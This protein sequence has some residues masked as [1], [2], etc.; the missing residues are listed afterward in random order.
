M[1][2][3]AVIP[4]KSSSSRIKNK[5]IK[6]LGDK[7]LFIHTLEKLLLIEELD[8]VWIDTDSHDIIKLIDDYNYTDYK[9][10]I[11]DKKY[12]NNTCDG[13]LLLEN[14]INNIN[15]D[16]YIQVLCTS[17]FTTNK[18]IKKCID[19]LKSKK[20]KSVIGCYKD[21]LYLWNNNKPIYDI[22]NIPNSNTLN[23][24]IIESM[25]IYGIT[26]E[27]FLK[28]KIRIGSNPYLLSLDNEEKIDINY[29][30]DFIFAN[31]R[32]ELI[33]INELNYF[34]N[35]KIKLNSCILSDIL[36][37]LGY[38]NCVLQNFKLNI[39][40]KKIFGRVRPIQIRKL[41]NNENPNDIYKC[42]KSYNN[43]THGNI[44]FVNNKVDKKAYFGDLNATIALSKNAQGTIINGFTRDINNTIQ[45][46]YPVFYK[47]NTCSDVKYYGTL[48]YY[49]KP[50]TVNNIKIYVNNL[51]FADK[52]GIIIIPKKIESLV[53]KKSINIIQNE[54]NISTDIIL[55][56]KL[57]DII[58]DYGYF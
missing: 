57:D 34:K 48:D 17:P 4:V 1:K 42:L 8:E 40:T 19:L 10:F 2:T 20:Y 26:K 22:K 24:T 56:K 21:K 23:D 45:L 30:N 28:T 54:N 33:F 14:E 47:N 12:A 16:I 50:I 27:E 25:S 55:N 49:D 37:E 9:Y 46:D 58:K 15:A 36:N 6:L 39:D 38:T 51:L 41:K 31:K 29:I 32:A 43:I 53:I 13:N 5:N 11:R 7:P 35:L 44:I 3:I 52:D 18:T